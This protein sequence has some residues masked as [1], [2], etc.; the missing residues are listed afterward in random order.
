[1][2]IETIFNEYLNKKNSAFFYTPPIYK[3]SYSYLF[4]NPEETITAGNRNELIDS[5]K[6]IEEQIKLGRIGYGF[7]K[8]EAGLYLENKL[9]KLRRDS[10]SDF[11]KFYLFDKSNVIKIK[12]NEIDFQGWPENDYN[13]NSIK[14]N[15]SKEEFIYDIQKIKSFIEE[16]DTYQVNYTLKCRFNFSGSL[17][18]LFKSLVFN[19][20]AEYTA[21]I[22][23]GNNLILSVSPELFFSI[24]DSEII[25]KP[26]KG[27]IKRGINP[28]D[29]LVKYNLLKNE[30][31]FHAENL[32]ILDLLR[33]DLGRISKY[34]SVNVPNLYSVQKYESLYQL[35]SEVR[36]NLLSNITIEE[37]FTALFP[38]GSVTG[39]PKI[40]TMEIIN[41]LEKEERG[42]Y[43][44]AI[45]LF[46]EDKTTFNVAIRTLTINPETGAGEFGIGSGI[47]W[48]SEPVSEYNETLL[49]SWFLTR[50][51]NYFELFETMLIENGKIFLHDYHLERLKQAAEYFLFLYDEELINNEIL[52]LLNQI[53][54]NKKYRL[55][56][57]LNKWGKLLFSLNE[58]QQT[59]SPIKII[60]S[61]KKILT[62][63]RFQYFKTT[64]RKLYDDEYSNYTSQGYFDVIFFNELGNLAEGSISNIFV[65]NGNKLYTPPLNSGILPGVYRKYFIENNLQNAIEKNIDFEELLNADEIILTNSLRGM[66][67]VDQ[68]YYNKGI[69]K[70]F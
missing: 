55:K 54:S 70:G 69:V 43:T 6:M 28:E 66:I 51:D 14:Q 37:L 59:P 34:D 65:R 48:D 32:M 62:A 8:Y 13:I 52:H 35:I 53:E 36:A 38:C 60:M 17:L 3:D 57:T 56:L 41:V 10:D 7:L 20:S 18:S 63:N 19:Q 16:G 49:K 26:M 4:K 23:N 30:E 21:Y 25:C 46:L 68:L 12:S 42:I 2:T 15:K 27:T 39:A 40:R 31:K 47:T 44:G 22:N 50:P 24:K 58:F 29:D 67:K 1:M 9:R 45:G 64:N 5:F 33:N 11:L 61:D